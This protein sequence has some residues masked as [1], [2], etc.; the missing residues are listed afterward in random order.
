MAGVFIRFNSASVSCVLRLAPH[1]PKCCLMHPVSCYD[2]FSQ[3][4]S[5]AGKAQ[6]L[7]KE[8]KQKAVTVTTQAS[9]VTYAAKDIAQA[10]ERQME[11]MAKAKSMLSSVAAATEEALAAL[12]CHF[13][14]AY[15]EK[16]NHDLRYGTT[17]ET[18]G[19]R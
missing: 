3:P 14:V 1:A 15:F 8:V 9:A 6:D 2:F 4:I 5:Q 11:A 7:M 12:R 10:A 13:L 16:C 19:M 17:V 18:L